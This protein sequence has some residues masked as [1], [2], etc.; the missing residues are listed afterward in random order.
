M[1]LAEKFPAQSFV[2]DTRRLSGYRRRR[3]GHAEA[4]AYNLREMAKLKVPVIVTVI[5]RGIRRRP[6]IGVGDQV[7]CLKCNLLC[8]HQGLRGDTLKDAKQLIARPPACANCSGSLR[9]ENCGPD[10]E[11]PPNGLTL[12]TIKL[13]VI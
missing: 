7:M 4:I 2:I 12:T 1:K 5:A 3:A 6:G 13:L 8:H 9:R 11:E 10:F